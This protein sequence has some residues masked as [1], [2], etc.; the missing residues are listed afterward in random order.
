MNTKLLTIKKIAIYLLAFV[1]SSFL[2]SS[3]ANILLER[4]SVSSENI[5]FTIKGVFNLIFIVSGYF[6]T[7]KHIEDSPLELRA[8]L[9]KN[10]LFMILLSIISISI[11]IA[12]LYILGLYQV[13]AYQSTNEVAIILVALFAQS[14]TQEVLLRGIIYR[15]FSKHYSAISV[16]LTLST[17]LACLNMLLDGV[18]VLPFVSAFLIHFIL[19]MIYQQKDSLVLSAIINTCWIYATFLT[20]VLNEH[21]T[22]SAPVLS[23]AHENTLLS[24][25]K[26]GPESSIFG[27]IILMLFSLCLCRKYITRANQLST[28]AHQVKRSAR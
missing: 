25:G 13:I 14:M 23:R 3:T 12:L 15:Q 21:W 6:L 16:A 10:T 1:I 22:K 24:G 5:I 17:I 7:K 19:C 27:I 8:L 18:Y 4:M 2:A 11:V 28:Q 26:F 20:G 9:S